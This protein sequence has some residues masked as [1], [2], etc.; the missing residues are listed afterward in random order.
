MYEK[1]KLTVKSYIGN[2]ITLMLVRLSVKCSFYRGST[3]LYCM[4]Y[5]KPDDV[6]F[7]P[8]KTYGFPFLFVI[9]KVNSY[10]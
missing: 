4:P 9:V 10:T 7:I 2:I 6:C 1:D 3:A 5:F 8:Y